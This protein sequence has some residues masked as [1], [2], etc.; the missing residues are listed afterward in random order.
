M[1]THLHWIRNI[2]RAITSN[3]Q[4]YA[5]GIVQKILIDDRVMFE[6][7]DGGQKFVVVF[8]TGQ[9][10][11]CKL[12]AILLERTHNIWRMS[13]LELILFI[14][15]EVSQCNF[16]LGYLVT[17]LSALNFP[18]S[19]SQ[20]LLKKMSNFLSYSVI[21]YCQTFQ[22]PPLEHLHHNVLVVCVL[23]CWL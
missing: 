10:N 1:G 22:S 7:Q 15:G 8:N 14:Y 2:K 20:Y 12:T 13:S 6:E 18:S 5:D 23:H 17:V 19:F 4:G 16:T 3:P 11:V 9:V 21:L